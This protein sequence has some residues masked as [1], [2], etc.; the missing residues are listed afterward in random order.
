MKSWFVYEKQV[1]CIYVN[2]KINKHKYTILKIIS[3]IS[4]KNS[5]SKFSIIIK[6][7]NNL[8]IFIPLY[9]YSR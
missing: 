8:T 5:G 1:W 2:A 9:R 3:I 4:F 7:C 6:P